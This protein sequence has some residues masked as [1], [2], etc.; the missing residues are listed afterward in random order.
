MDHKNTIFSEHYIPNNRSKGDN[1]LQRRRNMFSN[2][3]TRSMKN[4]REHSVTCI[5][6]AHLLWSF[7]SYI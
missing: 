3:N 4:G 2:N 5:N 7:T 1:E 6:E